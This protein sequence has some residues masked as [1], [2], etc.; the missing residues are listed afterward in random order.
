MGTQAHHLLSLMEANPGDSALC[1]GLSQVSEVAPGSA[2]CGPFG[3]SGTY[4][5]A[6]GTVVQGTRKR[7]SPAFGSVTWQKTVANSHDN[8]LEVMLKHE[9]RALGYSLAYTWSQSLDQGSS[10][11]DPVNPVD[12]GL[13]RGLSAFI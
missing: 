12:P 9:G 3:E 13:S 5:R 8:A 7:F 6:D 11:A 4:T 2:T 1:L 10:L